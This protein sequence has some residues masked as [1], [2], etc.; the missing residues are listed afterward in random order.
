MS[1]IDN[2]VSRFLIADG[3]SLVRSG[4]RSI[5]NRLTDGLAE[6]I[7]AE[8][9]DEAMES[10]RENKKFNL[11]IL[12]T[13]LTEKAPTTGLITI[14]QHDPS[15]PVLLISSNDEWDIVF[16]AFR[17]GAV[18]FIPKTYSSEITLNAL[19]LILSGGVFLPYQAFTNQVPHIPT[20][21]APEAKANSD[22]C[23]GAAKLGGIEKI[24]M[25][26]R[27]RDILKLMLTGQS[28]KEIARSLGL[29]LGTVKN[30]V[31]VILRILNANN[32]SQAILNA[33]KIGA[34]GKKFESLPATSG[35][36]EYLV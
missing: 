2:A 26:P 25:A 13:K 33:I 24:S 22:S 20:P 32:R 8:S 17:L 31:A 3:Q 21:P 5:L 28:N 15:I 9:F 7:E 4:I 30:Q 29:A 19:R 10:I 27:Q 6:T 14:K 23:I 16:P 11:V 18:G 12:D 34:A 35:R 1:K 36:R